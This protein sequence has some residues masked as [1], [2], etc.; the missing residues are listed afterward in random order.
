MP[1]SKSASSGFPLPTTNF[2][3]CPGRMGETNWLRFR[4]ACGSDRSRRS[5]AKFIHTFSRGLRSNRWP[6][7]DSFFAFRHAGR[8]RNARRG[9][10]RAGKC[11]ARNREIKGNECTNV[12]RVSFLSGKIDYRK[13][14][15]KLVPFF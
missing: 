9:A 4:A 6:L 11:G 13:K 15:G 5:S 3:L 1:L 8:A 12:P 14:V 10:C 7:R 2:S